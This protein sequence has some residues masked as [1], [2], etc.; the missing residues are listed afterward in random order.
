MSAPKKPSAPAAVSEAEVRHE[1]EEHHDEAEPVKV[2]PARPDPSALGLK[3]VRIQPS[4]DESIQLALASAG[5]AADASKEIQ[6][7]K[8][9]VNDLV[10][11]NSRSNKVLL[12]TG[13]IFL[14]MAS[15]ALGVS[16]AFYFKA[17]NR[18]DSITNVNRDALMAFAEEVN[19]FTEAATRVEQAANASEK[20]LAALSTQQDEIK[21]ALQGDLANQQA[22]QAKLTENSDTINQMPAA[23]RKIVDDLLASNKLIIGQVADTRREQVKAMEAANPKVDIAKQIQDIVKTQQ[24]ASIRTATIAAQQ[25]PKSGKPVNSTDQMIKYP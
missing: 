19:A 6:R 23:T 15:I 7:L 22:I 14:F 3:P 5:T 24:A 10:A 25:K 9:Q 12:G 4:L 16:V 18:F 8:K 1:V 2:E 13:V 17:M 21:V 20:R 11:G